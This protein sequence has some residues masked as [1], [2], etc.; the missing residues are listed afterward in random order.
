M[1]A[2]RGV[3]AAIAVVALLGSVLAVA[4]SAQGT[5]PN[6]ADVGITDSQIRIAVV[7]DVDTPVQPGLFQSA[8]DSM[9]AWARSVNQQGGIAG[10]KVVI[11][12][13]D[14]HLSPDDTR[15]AIIKACS[16][17]FA[18]VGTEALFM[19][20]VDDM[21]A[22]KD[23]QGKPTGLPDLSGIAIDNHERCS[24]VTFLV[25]GD[26][27]FC[28]TLS[29]HPQTYTA[30]Q[31][32]CLYYLSQ[33]K[34]LHG[35]YI[36]PGDLQ[37][38]T[39]SQEVPFQA[40]VNLG[41]K[42]DATGFYTVSAMAPQSAL[43]PFVAAVKANNS[44]FVYQG[45]AFPVMVELRREAIAQGVNSVKIW[46]CNQGCYD[47]QFLAQGGTAVESTYTILTT[48]PFYSEYNSNASLKTLVHQLGG[49]NKLNGNGVE[50][51]LAAL[52][53]QDASQR[54]LANGG[55][56]TRASLLA[57]LK[58]EHSFT[59]QGILGPT[60]VG[61][62]VQPHC[63]VMAQVKNG[64]WVRAFPSKTGTFDCNP[65]NLVQLKLDLTG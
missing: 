62:H 12:F 6:A 15:N 10:R 11:D 25:N 2:S 4:A 32:D 28:T 42:K 14:S 27:S 41:I 36:L 51:W 26:A 52:L 21:V 8:V 38:A 1:R 16:Q 17:D 59:G 3:L 5:K 55:T 65:K 33:E 19:N 20:N 48:L 45:D 56:L 18:M 24:P 49:V 31:G 22:C 63:I 13:I 35:I 44:N 54:A 43:T 61:N 57:A 58:T 7:A 9:N 30:Q 40:C 50:A 34:N 29:D 60:D 23:A 64:K 47:A 53:F 46:A 39:N 37:E